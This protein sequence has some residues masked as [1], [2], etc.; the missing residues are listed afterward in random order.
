M[1]VKQLMIAACPKCKARFKIDESRMTLSGVKLRCSKCRTV[2][3]VRKRSHET[4]V[5]VSKPVKSAYTV[6]IANSDP[7][8]C[9]MVA[10]ILKG[11]NA[12][13]ISAHDG[14]YALEAVEKHRPE[15]AVLDVA[16]PGMYGFEVC[17]HIKGHPEL[18]RTNVILLASIY[19]KT[20]YKRNPTSLYGA[21]DYIE[22]HHLHDDLIPKINRLLFSPT[23]EVKPEGEVLK[24]AE[25]T[26]THEIKPELPTDKEI[27]SLKTE[28]RAIDNRDREIEKKAGRLAR[29]IVS[30]IALYSDELVSEGIKNGTIYKLLEDDIKEGLEHFKKKIPADIPAEKYLKKAFED[31]IAGRK[32]EIGL[33]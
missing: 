8:V 21:E 6:L 22:K 19:D 32:K 12:D 9:N 16:L 13:V 31:F 33:V 25:D 11:E 26:I 3:G 20:R 10:E 18:K 23:P 24:K 15:V 29:I 1:E 2:F 30:D 27:E 5:K 7:A 17:E 14:V 28:E 4:E